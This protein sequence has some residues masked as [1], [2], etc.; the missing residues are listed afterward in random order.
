MNRELKD[1]VLEIQSREKWETYSRLKRAISQ[2]IPRSDYRLRI[3]MDL[4]RELYGA[5]PDI[6]G[7]FGMALVKK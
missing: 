1:L 3:F 6:E 7:M 4:H 2:E 5:C